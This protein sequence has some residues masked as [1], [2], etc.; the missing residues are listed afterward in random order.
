MKTVTR[1]FVS[2]IMVVLLSPAGL[3]Q[4][5]NGVTLTSE[6]LRQVEVEN[7]KGETQ[8]DLVPVDKALPGEELIIR[9]TY[10]NSGTEPARNIVVINP[11]P[12]HMFYV[13]GSAAGDLTEPTFSIDSGKSFDVPEKLLVEGEEGKMKTAPAELYTHIRFRRIEALDPGLSDN[14]FF[15]AV[16][17]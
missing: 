16:L 12:D 8:I 3:A 14:V 17:K 4:A 6:V 11:V 7:E 13:A 1:L 15:R 9:I 2:F 10:T 5:E